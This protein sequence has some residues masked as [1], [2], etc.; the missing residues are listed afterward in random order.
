MGRKSTS[1]AQHT[2]I[3]WHLN[4]L[5]ARCITVREDRAKRYYTQISNAVEG[6]IIQ[7]DSRLSN[8][9][10]QLPNKARVD[11][12]IT[13]PPYYGMRT[14]LPD[15]WLRLWFAGGSPTVDYSTSGQL[16]HSNPA[17]FAAQLRKVWLNVGAVCQPGARLI[18]R[19]GGINDRKVAP[20][21]ILKQSLED[22]GWRIQTL[23]SAGY[24]SQGR[25]QALH[26]SN[27]N[28]KALEEYDVWARWEG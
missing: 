23:K 19:F 7:G 24:A 8:T 27:A 3:S 12:V 1:S 16:D 18:I 15:Q 26:F 4:H 14:Y 6:V 10:S 17:N 20:L 13:S 5:N 11:W 25:R 22:S 9:F 28:K 21:P 2:A